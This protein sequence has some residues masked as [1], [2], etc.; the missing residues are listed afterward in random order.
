MPHGLD[1]LDHTTDTG[2]RL[3]VTDVG[4]QRPQPQWTVTVLAVGRDDRLRLDRVTQ[5]GAGSVTLNH[6]DVR[7]GQTSVGQRLT[8]HPLLRRTIRR[9]QPVRRTVLVHRRTLDYTEDLVS[10]E[11]GVG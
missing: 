11:P 3:R 7:S 5:R 10:I 2:S 4:L 6:I 9:G 8:D 1:H